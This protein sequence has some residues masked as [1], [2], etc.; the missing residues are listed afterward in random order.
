M[1]EKVYKM[2][3]VWKPCYLNNLREYLKQAP[4]LLSPSAVISGCFCNFKP[5]K[6]MQIYATPR[7]SGGVETR[8][9]SLVHTG[10]HWDICSLVTFG[11]RSSFNKA[12]NTCPVTPQHHVSLG[13]HRLPRVLSGTQRSVPAF[14]PGTIYFCFSKI[15][16]FFPQP[17]FSVLFFP[18]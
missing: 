6:W 11:T 14:I 8:T 5:W 13:S 2:Q 3:I 16:C 18:Q 10:Y 17:F 1:S 9:G 4:G 12:Q 7:W 15:N